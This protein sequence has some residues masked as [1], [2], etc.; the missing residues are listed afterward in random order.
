MIVRIINYR[1]TKL[2]RRTV[3][4]IY[5][6]LSVSWSDVLTSPARVF[7]ET[8]LF[9]CTCDCIH[10]IAFVLLLAADT[11]IWI[12][13]MSRMHSGDL[14]ISDSVDVSFPFHERLTL[15]HCSTL[16]QGSDAVQ[17]GYSLKNTVWAKTGETISTTDRTS[18]QNAKRNTYCF[19]YR[20]ADQSPVCKKNTRHQT[21]YA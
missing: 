2:R 21:L 5:F 13:R 12:L 18:T 1:V 11:S 17:R 9:K 3:S 16:Q 8:R 20:A 19:R 14:Q 7:T 15:H 4:T 10:N 6:R